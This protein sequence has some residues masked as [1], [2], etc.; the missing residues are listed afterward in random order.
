MLQATTIPEIRNPANLKFISNTKV[1]IRLL[2]FLGSAH[3]L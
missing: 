2:I 3:A 1:S